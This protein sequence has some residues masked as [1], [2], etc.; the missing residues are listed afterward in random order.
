MV[1]TRVGRSA[2][3]E[4]SARTDQRK[5]A[6][7]PVQIAQRHDHPVCRARHRLWKCASRMEAARSA[8]GVSRVSATHRRGRARNLGRAPDPGQMRHP[9]TR[10][11]ARLAGG[12][13]ALP[14][15]L[16]PTYS[17]G[18]N[19]VESCFGLM[20]QQAI[21][22]GSFKSVKELI[23]KINPFV[24]FFSRN[25]KPFAWTATA[26]SIFQKTRQT[27]FANSWEATGAPAVADTG[28]IRYYGG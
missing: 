3:T 19:Q 2:S 4:N 18:L 10:Q 17:S 16:H 23:T 15:S 1:E 5:L 9:Q 25:S 28:P 14:S 6:D 13:A 22:R 21:R 24:Q 7:L 8:S 20:T 27:M 11:G 12:N 26:Y